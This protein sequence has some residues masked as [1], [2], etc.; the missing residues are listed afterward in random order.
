MAAIQGVVG[1]VSLIFGLIGI[2]LFGNQLAFTIN[3]PRYGVD[4]SFFAGDTSTSAGQGVCK[5]TN[6]DFC[7]DSAKADYRALTIS[8]K[9]IE[10]IT[11]F[12]MNPAL[13]GAVALAFAG[14]IG[15]ASYAGKAEPETMAAAFGTALVF[16]LVSFG[17]ACQISAVTNY[18]PS[19]EVLKAA[20][21]TL[22]EWKTFYSALCYSDDFENPGIT[23]G[24]N[25]NERCAPSPYIETLLAFAILN[26]LVNL[27]AVLYSVCGQGVVSTKGDVEMK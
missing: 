24:L 8:L 10:V 23:N 19:L 14:L 22:T 1:F 13:Y 7:T 20:E 26:C 17:I 21:T 3:P 6:Q 2:G 11:L 15:M 5:L 27:V 16:N 12:L 4:E 25:G 9:G 18:G